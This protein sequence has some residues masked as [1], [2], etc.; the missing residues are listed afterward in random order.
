MLCAESYKHA[1]SAESYK[2][3]ESYKL[4]MNGGQL[5]E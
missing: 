1:D 4:V 2:P 5:T 3:A